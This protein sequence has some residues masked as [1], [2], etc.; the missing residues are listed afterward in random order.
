MGPK[1]SCNFGNIPFKEFLVLPKTCITYSLWHENRSVP[2][3]FTVLGMLLIRAAQLRAQYNLRPADAL[4]VASGLVH[5]TT[6]F[7]TNDAAWK[8]LSARLEI[9]ALDDFI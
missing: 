7:V 6:A 8:R 5:K 1:Y 2:N 9:M 3:Y 4:Q